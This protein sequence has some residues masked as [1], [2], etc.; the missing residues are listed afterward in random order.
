MEGYIGQ[1]I[2][3]A[4]NF[5]PKYWAFCAGQIMAISQNTA[6][7]SILGTTYGGDGIQTFAL[8]DLRG[9]VAIGQGQGPGLSLYT[10][11]QVGGTETVTLLTSQIPAHTHKLM[12]STVKG[13]TNKP[14]GALLSEAVVPVQRGVSNDGNIYS[15][16]SADTQMSAAAVGI[17]GQSQAHANIQPYLTLNYI[18]CLQGIFPSRN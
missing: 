2:L 16:G 6:L 12:G 17:E 9:R 15:S 10:L 13:N 5:A 11:G 3:F 14:A 18:I 8:P 1:I 4:G 7:F